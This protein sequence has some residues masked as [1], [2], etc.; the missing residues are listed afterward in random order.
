LVFGVGVSV[1]NSGNG[2][3]LSDISVALPCGRDDGLVPVISNR[4]TRRQDD[5]SSKPRAF[6][7][8]LGTFLPSGIDLGEF[9]FENFSLFQ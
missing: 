5:Q 7:L 1:C 9:S 3:D 8:R 4:I 6:L 2:I